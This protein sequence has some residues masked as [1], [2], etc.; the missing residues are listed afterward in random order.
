MLRPVRLLWAAAHPGMPRGLL[1]YDPTRQAVSFFF[2]FPCFSI[3][4]LFFN[5]SVYF[6]IFF[7]NVEICKT[8]VQNLNFFKLEQTLSLE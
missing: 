7:H 3:S 2:S 8:I 1:G 6:W 4:S 5:K